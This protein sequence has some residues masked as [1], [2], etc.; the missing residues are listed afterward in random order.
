MAAADADTA[1]ESFLELERRFESFLRVV[2]VDPAH[3]R[4]HSPLLASVLLDACSLIE[5]VLKSSMDNARYNTIPNIANIRQ[6]R[7]SQNPPFLNIGHLR[8]VFRA[9]TFYAKPVWYLPRGESS[10]PWYVWR[11]T[12]GQPKW[13][14]AYNAVKHSRFQNASQ[15]TLLTTF[16]ALKAL[17]LAIVQS[18]DFR[19]RL[20]DRGLIRCAGFSVQQLKT[21][22]VQW[23]LIQVQW[24]SPVIVRTQLFG[25]KYLSQGSPSRAA[26]ASVFI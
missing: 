24:Q 3:N 7:Y 9:D 19:E 26:D 16:H 14:S 25:Y 8:S 10:F 5:T 6:M 23:E 17:F 1:I 18:L 21:Y 22:A 4:V 15:A 13:W 12:S 11:S 20:I 2:P